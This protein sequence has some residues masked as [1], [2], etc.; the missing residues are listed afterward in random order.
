MW[1][2]RSESPSSIIAVGVRMMRMREERPPQKQEDNNL[3]SALGAIIQG[4]FLLFLP[5]FGTKM[6]NKFQPTSATFLKKFS[7]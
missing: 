7:N 2:G 4:V 6:K 3:K 1:V 5:I